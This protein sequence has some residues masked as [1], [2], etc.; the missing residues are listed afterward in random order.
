MTKSDKE[1]G[2]IFGVSITKS[3]SNGILVCMSQS[4]YRRTIWIQASI[5]IPL[6]NLKLKKKTP[7]YSSCHPQGAE[8]LVWN[9]AFRLKHLKAFDS[10]TSSDKD[11]QAR[12]EYNMI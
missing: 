11:M 2:I 3:I 9:Q 1:I 5:T 8:N 4:V 6:T 7:K 12:Q 10:S